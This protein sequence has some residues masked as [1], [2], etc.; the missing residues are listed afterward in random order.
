MRGFFPLCFGI[1]FPIFAAAKTQIKSMQTT[2]PES[3]QAYIRPA[4]RYIPM[5]TEVPFLQTNTEIIVDDGQE[6]GWD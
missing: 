6:H 3:P 1:L 4:M 5:N 2:S